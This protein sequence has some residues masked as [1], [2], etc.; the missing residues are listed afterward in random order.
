MEGR[1]VADPGTFSIK[2]STNKTVNVTLDYDCELSGSRKKVVDFKVKLTVEMEGVPQ[3]NRLNFRIE[4]FDYSVAF[5]PYM[6]YKIANEDLAKHMVMHSLNRLYE[7][8]VFGDGW[9]LFT[10]DYPH[11]HV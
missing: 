10:R 11:F 5:S 8:H 7:T 4:K 6:D 2:M 9:H 3:T 1:C